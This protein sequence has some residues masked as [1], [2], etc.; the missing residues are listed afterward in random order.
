LPICTGDLNR[1]G[2]IKGAG[3]IGGLRKTGNYLLDCRFNKPALV[4][5]IRRIAKYRE[6]IHFTSL[7]AIDFLSELPSQVSGDVLLMADPPY[8]N[9]GADLYT[10]FYKPEDHVRL[11]QA[12]TATD[13]P[14]LTTY[15]NCP[16]ISSLCAGQRQYVFDI[17]YSVQTKRLGGE[18][19][20][21]S[22]N[23]KLP[24]DSMLR[25][26][27]RPLGHQQDVDCM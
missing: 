16:E 21:L 27:N 11:A 5:R 8:F 6:R 2:I 25:E 24:E 22:A 3:V 12:I 13:L 17:Q 10:S 4:K 9:K 7:D 14:W 23:L 26:A 15:D 1:S 19:L 18:L 20:I